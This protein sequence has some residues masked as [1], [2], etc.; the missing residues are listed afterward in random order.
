MDQAR[1]DFDKRASIDLE[2]SD[3]EFV[4]MRNLRKARH[5]DVNMRAIPQLN[6]RAARRRGHIRRPKFCRSVIYATQRRARIW[7]RTYGLSQKFA[8]KKRVLSFP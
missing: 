7:P 4:A 2:I 6:M 8:V 1:I 5:R 3:S